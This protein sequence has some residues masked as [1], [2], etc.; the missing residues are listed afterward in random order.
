MDTETKLNT[1]FW[2]GPT[3]FI[4]MP[5]LLWCWTRTQQKLFHRLYI[6]TKKTLENTTHG[7]NT[8]PIKKCRWFSQNHADDSTNRS[9][10]SDKI[11][12]VLHPKDLYKCRILSKRLPHCYTGNEMLDFMQNCT[13]QTHPHCTAVILKWPSVVDGTLK[14]RNYL[15]YRVSLWIIRIIIIGQDVSSIDF[16]NIFCL[17]PLPTQTAKGVHMYAAIK[18]EVETHIQ[19]RYICI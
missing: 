13:P 1:L 18:N 4:Q 11:L 9:N 16:L 19:V 12:S 14:S 10:F 5:I 15:C 17:D 2:L 8:K 3:E 6:C 7:Q